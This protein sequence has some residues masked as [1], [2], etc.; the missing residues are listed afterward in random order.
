MD[1]AE[2]FQLGGSLLHLAEAYHFNDELRLNLKLIK[3]DKFYRNIAATAAL[4]GTR[5]LRLI[6]TF[7]TVQ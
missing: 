7:E 3:N 4:E 6:L 1:T 2:L 5:Y